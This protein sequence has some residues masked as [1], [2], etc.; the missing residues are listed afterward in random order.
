MKV[1]DIIRKDKD[2]ILSQWLK[3]VK[4]QIS[5]AQG[6]TTPA[7]RNDVPDLLEEMI[8]I[9]DE[10]TPKEYLHESVDHGRLRAAM[11]G[12]TLSHVV[13]EYRLLLQVVFASID[14]VCPIE[15]SDRN[16]IITTV[17]SAI[18]H[19]AQAFFEMRQEKEIKAKEQAEAA[20][21]ELEE[22]GQLR[23]DFIGTVTHD[24]RNPLANTLMLLELLKSN[25]SSEPAY[26][27]H[28]NAIQ[29]SIKQAD[30]LIR[31]LLDVNLIKSGGKLPI[32]RQPCDLIEEVKASVEEFTA[33]YAGE[34]NTQCDQPSVSGKYDCKALRRALDNLIQNAIKYGDQKSA[35]TLRCRHLDDYIELS[36]HNR[37]NP[38][39]IDQQAKIFTRYYQ[40]E[41]NM[42]KKGWG[43]GLSL[44]KGI[45]E[46]HGG[47]V[48]L[49]S[50][51]AEGTSFSIKI[52]K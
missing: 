22:E 49:V 24:L 37:G 31:N 18:E 21:K 45:A 7:L 27:K 28:L 5:G 50:S 16:K 34:I 26:L 38:I 4:Q 33:Q 20:V 36:V 15:P 29:M 48:D 19:A 6:Q 23:D 30:T 44:V 46:A 14:Q 39:P 41:D 25:L 40:A 11:Q 47:K 2:K 17:I 1:F 43:I 13:K 3:A 32:H 51:K 9:L 35:I 42:H 12:Y 10:D 52:P 8:T